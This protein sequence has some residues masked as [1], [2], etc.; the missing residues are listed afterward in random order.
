MLFLRARRYDQLSRKPAEPQ[1]EAGA[2]ARCTIKAADC[3]HDNADPLGWGL[4]RNVGRSI[5]QVGDEVHALIGH[6]DV[7]PTCCAT[8]QRLRQRVALFAI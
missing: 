3:A 8:H 4:D 2:R 7:E 6:S 5:A 1:H